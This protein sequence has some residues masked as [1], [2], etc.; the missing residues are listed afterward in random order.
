VRK[1]IGSDSR[2]GPKF[3]YPGVGYGG[4]C[5]PK[6]VKALIKT[7]DD[8]HY[9]LRI[10]KSVEEVNNTQKSVLVQKILRHFNG[11]VEGLLFAMWGLSFKPHTDD[12]R[13][14]PSVV[15]INELT[16]RGARVKAYDPVA[17]KEAQKLLHASITYAADQYDALIDADALILVTEWPEFRLPN[18]KIM[19]KL[20]K[21]RLIFDGRNIYEPD[22]MKEYGYTYYC[23]GRK[24]VISAS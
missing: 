7:A 19:E 21:Q 13:E 24:P 22:D 10:L 12:M 16:A 8:N 5:F 18:F 3:I 2:I 11:N 20:L 4:S 15:I 14:A 9:P 6:D 23:I 1:G 17:M